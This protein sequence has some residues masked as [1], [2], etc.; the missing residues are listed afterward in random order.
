MPGRLRRNAPEIVPAIVL[1]R[2]AVDHDFA[3]R[4][5]G[6]SLLADAL[7]RS[8]FASTTIGV[9]AIIVHPLGPGLI[10][11]YER[12]GF[13]SFPGDPLAMFIEIEKIAA[14]VHPPS[15]P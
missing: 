11:L 12:L 14:A 10:P 1:G 3:G 15:R 9:R 6:G 13:S 4:G 8:L 2:L 5:L 7:R